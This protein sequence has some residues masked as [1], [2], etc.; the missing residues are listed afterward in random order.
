MNCDFPISKQVEFSTG[1][2]M[3]KVLGICGQPAVVTYH[4]SNNKNWPLTGR[5]EN[6]V[7]DL[8]PGIVRMPI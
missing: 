8:S 2:M 5:C 3:S 7:N 4:S 1:D 6:H